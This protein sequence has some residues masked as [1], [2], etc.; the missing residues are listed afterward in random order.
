MTEAYM[1]T[2]GLTVIGDQR[3]RHLERACREVVLAGAMSR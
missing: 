1:G 2:R 3:P